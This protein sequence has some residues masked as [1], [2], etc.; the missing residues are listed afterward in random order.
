MVRARRAG[1]SLNAHPVNITPTSAVLVCLSGLAWAVA[2]LIAVADL[3]STK[4]LAV[5]IGVG[6]TGAVCAVALES[7]VRVVR[8][9]EDHAQRVERATADHAELLAK[10][11]L[12][13][14]RFFELGVHSDRLAQE[15]AA[16]L[17]PWPSR[18]T[19]SFRVYKGDAG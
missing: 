7:M 17:H 4:V 9:V 18:G 3:T 19:G 10:H 16:D 6:A 15:D 8:K 13:L 1:P 12:A 5:S 2:V 11:V 14:D